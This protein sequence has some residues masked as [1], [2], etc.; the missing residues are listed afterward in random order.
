MPV[1]Q[2]A[3]IRTQSGENFRVAHAGPLSE[4]NS[5]KLEVPALKRTVSGKLFINQFLQLTGMEISMNQL[6]AGAGVP[7]YHQHKENEEVYVFIGGKGQMQIDGETFDVKEGSIV[8]VSPNG[9]RTLRNNSD[10]DLFFLCVQAKDGSLNN[11]N[12]E[13]GIKSDARVEW[14]N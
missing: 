5:Y 6:P 8:R 2:T 7:F 1:T 13:D 12:I 3:D 4:L 14:P 9:V 11:A 10:A